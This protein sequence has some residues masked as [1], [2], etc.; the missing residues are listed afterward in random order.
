MALLAE[1]FIILSV[2]MNHT[3]FFSIPSGV[4]EAFICIDKDGLKNDTWPDKWNRLEKMNMPYHGSLYQHKLSEDF[5]PTSI[6][7]KLRFIFENGTHGDTPSWRTIILQLAISA[8][9]F[10]I[11]LSLLI[12]VKLYA[13]CSTV[14]NLILRRKMLN[15]ET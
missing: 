2:V 4:R 9:T 11:V 6:T 3:I 1:S 12:T 14:Y 5:T 7:Y 8:C 15:N 13:I 10:Y